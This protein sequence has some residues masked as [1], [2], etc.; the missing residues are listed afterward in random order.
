MNFAAPFW[1]GG[2]L[3][4]CTPQERAEPQRSAVHASGQHATGRALHS[5]EARRPLNKIA[6]RR[7]RMWQSGMPH[8][9]ALLIFHLG[10]AAAS[11]SYSCAFAHIEQRDACNRVL[12]FPELHALGC[13]DSYSYGAGG[14]GGTPDADCSTAPSPPAASACFD[15]SA[16]TGQN[17]RNAILL[18]SS[19]AL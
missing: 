7:S 19:N 8:F 1:Y 15:V 4:S 17:P 11:Y 9:A 6:A 12:N 2:S 3:A 5:R 16:F 10:T 13:A 18:I 14:G